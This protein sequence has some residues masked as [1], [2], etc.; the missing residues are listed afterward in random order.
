MFEENHVLARSLAGSL[1]LYNLASTNCITHASDVLYFSTIPKCSSSEQTYRVSNGWSWQTLMIQPSYL[2]LWYWSVTFKDPRMTLPCDWQQFKGY[3]RSPRRSRSIHNS[4]SNQDRASR[5]V[6]MLFLYPNSWRYPIS[7]PLTLPA[8]ACILVDV[9]WSPLR[10]LS[11]GS[12]IVLTISKRWYLIDLFVSRLFPR[13]WPRQGSL[14]LLNQFS[15]LVRMA[16]TTKRH[17]MTASAMRVVTKPER[18]SVV[19]ALSSIELY[20]QDRYKN[21]PPPACSL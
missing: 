15:C 3:D 21:N 18:H 11:N 8:I 2:P 1:S 14:E 6:Q 7:R 10:I 13:L 17:P 16:K 4:I 20:P 9:L 19:F 12:S 5:G